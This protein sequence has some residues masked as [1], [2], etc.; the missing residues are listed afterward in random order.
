MNNICP[1]FICYY[2]SNF[3]NFSV[4][5]FKNY[6]ILNKILKN[7]NLIDITIKELFKS[8]LETINILRFD[9]KFYICPFLSPL[10]VLYTE[11]SGK[12]YFYLAE[13]FLVTDSIDKEI[14]I[15]LNNTSEWLVPEFQ[16]KKSKISFASN[17]C[18]LGYLFYRIVFN[19]KPFKDEKERK[20]KKIPSINNDS[21]YKKLIEN[22]ININFQ[23]R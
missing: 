12:E 2:F 7:K 8:I 17:I 9:D 19:K 3:L 21:Q 14:Q 6:K 11:S 23:K 13:I 5:K 22:C 18:C 15:E 4:F 16:S 10:N 1:D 20:E